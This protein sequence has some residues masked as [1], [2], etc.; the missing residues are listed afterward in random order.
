MRE[1]LWLCGLLLIDSLSW[2]APQP[3]FFFMG[4]A[5]SHAYQAYNA[6]AALILPS[7]YLFGLNYNWFTSDLS[8]GPFRTYAARAGRYTLEDSW[9]FFGAVT[10]EVTAYKQTTVGIDFSHRIIGDQ[11]TWPSGTRLDALLKFI[12]RMHAEGTQTTPDMTVHI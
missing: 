2:A 10:P 5:G 7:G 12:R 9:L 8:P 6:D 11:I 4:A 3:S 1:K